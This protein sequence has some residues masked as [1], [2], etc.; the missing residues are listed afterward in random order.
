MPYSKVFTRYEHDT[1]L[2]RDVGKNVI[3]SLQHYYG[4][5]GTPFFSLV[6]NGVKFNQYV[7]V[8]QVGN[9]QI[10]ILPKIDRNTDGKDIW[11][12][13]LIQM[14]RITSGIEAYATS[15]SNLK[16]QHNSIFN[17]YIELFIN[18]CEK[19]TH[20]GL[21]K[22][23]HKQKEN[24]KALKGRLDIPGQ[25][26]YNIVHKERF[27]VDYSTYDQ[28]HLI[29][30]ILKQ[31]L[32]VL[33]YL[34]SVPSLLNRIKRL[35]LYFENIQQ[36]Y[37]SESSFNNL[38]FGRKNQHYKE[39]LKIARMILLNYHPDIR[40]GHNDVLALMFDMNQLWEKYITMQFKKYLR[41]EYQISVQRSKVFWK[42]GI[43]DKKIKPDLILTNRLNENERIILDTK[44]K[45]PD[46][47][48]PGENDLRQ[49]FA[50]N[51]LFESRLS[52]LLYP[53][54]NDSI[55]GEFQTTNGGHCTALQLNVI[56][57]AG[58]LILDRSLVDPITSLLEKFENE[59]V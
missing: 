13:V 26:R 24:K 15:N 12:D 54:K 31:T 6:H 40:M 58:K 4:T 57:S 48:L 22:R 23:Y 27:F 38:H 59:Y 34:T 30:Q 32:L 35:L 25:I 46:D 20:R 21:I 11:R 17:L 51:R 53:G 9:K 50:Y 41:E 3:E 2:E 19:L 36:F 47:R 44:W 33:G 18:E 45:I 16:I 52:V 8:I 29:N 14:L 28:D 37:P 42:N 55:I 49:M 39:A 7:G 10:E 5:R 56:D 43:S 1:L